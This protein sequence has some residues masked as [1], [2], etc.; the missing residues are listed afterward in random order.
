MSK[1]NVNLCNIEHLNYLF[2][3]NHLRT[4]VFQNH[5][6]TGA[7][8]HLIDYDTVYRTTP[9]FTKSAK[10]IQTNH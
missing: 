7:L 4:L 3:S 10:Y 9:G 1:K 8:Y 6:R 2:G 5:L